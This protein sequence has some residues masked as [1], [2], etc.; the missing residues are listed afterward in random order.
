MRNSYKIALSVITI[1]ILITITIGT[2][3]SFYS[4]SD[5]QTDPNS[6]A[7]T[8]FDISFNGSNAITLRGDGKYAYPMSES[9]ATAADKTPYTFTITN[10]CSTANANGG[11]NYDVSL[12]TLVGKTSNLTSSLRYKLNKTAPTAVN[13]TSAMLSSLDDKLAANIKSSY[14]VTDS[15]NLIS[16]TLAPNE[17]VTYDL[18][19][20]IDEN[21]GNSIMDSTFDGK[22]LVY[23]YM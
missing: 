22:I 3:Y 14:D 23:A 19:L 15:Y 6:L 20:W 2:S 21:A 17:S 1:M 16:G 12:N 4:V 5:T 7:T 13:G 11:I 8:C 10:T 9:T 18:Y